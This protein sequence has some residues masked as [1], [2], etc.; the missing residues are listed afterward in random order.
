MFARVTTVQGRPGAIDD[1]TRVI[2]ND[3]IPA[4]TVLDGFRGGYWLADRRTGTVLGITLFDTEGD[5][6]VS[7]LA[8][9]KIRSGATDKLGAEVLDV[10][11]YEV[12]ARA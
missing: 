9:A 5:L 12:I 2:E 4:A 8:A 3:V 11:R 10:S 1:A 7:E 6:E